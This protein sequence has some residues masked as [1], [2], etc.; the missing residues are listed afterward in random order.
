VGSG[1]QLVVK[2]ELSWFGTVVSV[3][4]QVQSLL[5]RNGRFSRRLLAEAF[6]CV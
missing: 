5:K 1:E 4:D 3:A 6:R 2:A